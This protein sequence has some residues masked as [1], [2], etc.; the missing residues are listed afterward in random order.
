MNVI[1]FSNFN[2]KIKQ[3]I[4]KV[5]IGKEKEIELVIVSFIVGGHILIEDVPGVGKT[6]L[7]KSFARSVGVDFKRIQFTPDLLPSDITGINFYNTKISDFEFRKGPLFSNIILADEINR[8]TPR[9]Q[10]SLLEAMEERQITVDGVTRRLGF[11][12]M[13]LATQNPVE[14]FGTFP[15]PEAQLDR[16]LMKI[17]MGYPARNEEIEIINRFSEGFFENELESVVNIDEIE[18]VKKNYVHVKATEDVLSYI[19]DIVEATRKSDK[20]DLGVSPRGTLALFK[21]CQAYAAINKRDFIIPE[22]VKFLAPYVLNHRIISKQNASDN[23][24]LINSILN[25]IPVPLEKI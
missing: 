1:I 12:F 2:N 11:P 20:I 23:F 18:Y 15:L 13:V 6:T 9:T 21:A 14:T 4:S 7:V 8:A 19:M 17:S 3:N 16:F 5:I 10:S 24:S 22:D 25:E